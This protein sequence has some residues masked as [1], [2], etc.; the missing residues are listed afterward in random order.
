M[1]LFIAIIGALAAGI[2]VVFLRHGRISDVGAAITLSIIV[3]AGILG[4]TA[5]I[6]AAFPALKQ[7]AANYELETGEYLE[8]TPQ[9]G[10]TLTCTIEHRE[11][12]Q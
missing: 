8:C 2:A 4:A 9:D 10:D 6:T 7:P 5:L 11:D 1:N 12:N 3:A